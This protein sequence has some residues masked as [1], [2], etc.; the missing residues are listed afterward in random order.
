M[1]NESENDITNMKKA[2][3][4][5]NNASGAR[6][7]ATNKL[8]IKKPE[9]VQQTN[10]VVKGLPIGGHQEVLGGAT[11]TECEYGCCEHARGDDDHTN[12]NG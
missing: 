4:A 8:L 11:S 6:G 3:A 10:N 12:Q 1:R 5:I 2:S 7:V 9:N